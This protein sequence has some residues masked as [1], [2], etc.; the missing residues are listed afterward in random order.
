MAAVPLPTDPRCRTIYWERL[1]GGGT[2]NTFGIDTFVAGAL[3]WA[4]DGNAV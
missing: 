4:G 1:G 2:R 3:P